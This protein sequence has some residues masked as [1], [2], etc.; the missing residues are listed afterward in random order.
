MNTTRLFRTVWRVNGV[1]LLASF[2]LLG[3]GA[4]VAIVAEFLPDRLAGGTEPAVA[5]DPGG[6][7]LVLG[8]VEEVDGTPYVLLPLASK[9]DGKFSSG[10]SSE[11]RNLLFHD[12]A[13][14]KARW[15]R[16]DHAAAIASY[17]LLRAD[18]PEDAGP[19]EPRRERPVRWI[20]Y[21]IAPADTD[22]DGEVTSGDAL[23]IAVSGPGGDPPTTVLTGVD[24]VLGY[25]P[26]RGGTLSVFF[27]RG[28]RYVV[29]EIDLVARK[30]R[31]ER[32]LPRS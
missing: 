26:P 24:E 20:R 14:G 19:G 29:G 21:E 2:L 12:A 27:R 5:V 28:H 10:G 6:E 3:G 18:E 16:P 25:A 11:T 8:S 22:R 30:L 7:R 4:L 31:V 15:L 9:R 1:L 23:E 17:A 13:S 32:E